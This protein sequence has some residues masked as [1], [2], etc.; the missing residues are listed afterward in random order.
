[1]AI[2]EQRN[3]FAE[4]VSKLVRTVCRYSQYGCREQVNHEQRSQHEDIC[5]YL[6]IECI[7]GSGRDSVAKCGWRGKKS[8]L[9]DHVGL[10]HGLH[11]VHVG[12]TMEDVEGGDFDRSSMKIILL[13]VF[14]ELFWLTVKHDVENNTRVEAVQYIGSR[15]RATGFEYQH[16]LKSLD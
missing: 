16:E 6:P 3:D 2:T 12:P 5:P 9:F 7:A 13:C 1:S 10:V 11:F 14:E 8:E 4:S 15:T